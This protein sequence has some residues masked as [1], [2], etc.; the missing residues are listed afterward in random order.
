MKRRPPSFGCRQTPHLIDELAHDLER[1]PRFCSSGTRATPTP[2]Q[3]LNHRFPR[4]AGFADCF[5]KRSVLHP[6]LAPRL[7]FQ[8][9][10]ASLP[11]PPSHNSLLSSPTHNLAAAPSP[12]L[13]T[14][15]RFPSP[16]IITSH[17]KHPSI[18]HRHRTLHRAIATP[19]YGPDR[20]RGRPGFHQ[21]R[22]V[23]R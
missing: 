14:S 7:A 8:T 13:P 17:M 22:P 5:I 2:L 9:N 12:L 20:A 15:R 11:Q 10:Y 18:E 1:G 19:A 16:V 21:L 3:S 6:I 4:R 23:A